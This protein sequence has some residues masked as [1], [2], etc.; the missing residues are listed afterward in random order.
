MTSESPLETCSYCGRANPARLSACAE[1]GTAL[2]SEPPL[3]A[4]T[5]PARKSQTLA[6]FLSLIFGP[7][8]LIYVGGWWQAFVMIVVG[9]PFILTHTGGL[10]LT[11]G[12]RL[13]A[14]AW[15]YSL[16][17]EHDDAPNQQR[18]AG[19]LLDEAARLESVDF[20]KAIAA[21]EEVIRQYP[22]T[23]A[24]KQAASAIETLKLNV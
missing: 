18:D 3:P 15:A 22:D 17:V 23:R 16:V 24:S 2:V 14:A 4:R 5:E 13:I 9:L 8:G 20:H 21:Y 10:W 1:C 6:V 7:L 19:R 11:I 12:G